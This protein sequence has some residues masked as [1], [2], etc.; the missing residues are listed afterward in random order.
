M[1]AANIATEIHEL[2]LNGDVVSVILDSH[3]EP[4]LWEEEEEEGGPEIP[5]RRNKYSEIMTRPT[6]ASHES[7]PA[8][9]S[10][11]SP[12][13]SEAGDTLVGVTEVNFLGTD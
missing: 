12:F 6:A 8:D 5:T 9:R 10:D 11:P 7:S 1:S 2:D 3:Q 4:A 13:G